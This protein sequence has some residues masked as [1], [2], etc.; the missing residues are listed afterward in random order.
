MDWH[1]NGERLRKS[2]RDGVIKKLHKETPVDF[3]RSLPEPGPG[4]MWTV[5][6]RREGLSDEFV[7]ALD[8][9]SDSDMS[10]LADYL[11]SDKPLSPEERRVLARRLPKRTTGR[12]KNTQLRAATSVACMFYEEWRASNKKL[13]ISDHG[14]CDDMKGYASKWVV[15]DWFC[16]GSC[17]EKLMEHT[18]REFVASVRELMEKPKHLRDTEEGL[19]SFPLFGWEPKTSKSR[20]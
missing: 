12:P 19:I 13:R 11:A 10:P 14:H 5:E 2:W 3:I 8:A 9:S 7:A 20:G 4:M 6:R 18:G 1:E 16:Q 15:E 17:D